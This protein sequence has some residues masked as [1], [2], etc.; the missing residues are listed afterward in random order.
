LS[1]FLVFTNVLYLRTND[2][3]LKVC[4][5]HVAWECTLINIMT[6]YPDSGTLRHEGHVDSSTILP[7]TMTS[8]SPVSS[9]SWD[10]SSESSVESG[11]VPDV[12][13]AEP[14]SEQIGFGGMYYEHLQQSHYHPRWEFKFPDPV[15]GHSAPSR[16]LEHSADVAVI[17]SPQ[18]VGSRG[19]FT[20]R[21]LSGPGGD[22]ISYT[23]EANTKITNRLRRRCFN[24]KATETSTWRRSVLSPGKLVGFQGYLTERVHLIQSQLCNKC[25][26]F[27]RTHAIPRPQKFPRRR[28]HG[29]KVIRP[30]SSH[31]DMRALSGSGHVNRYSKDI[32]S[33]SLPITSH[34]HALDPISGEIIP[35][36]TPWNSPEPPARV[37]RC[38]ATTEEPAVYHPSGQ[39]PPTALPGAI[40]I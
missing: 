26:L 23:D 5:F 33:P 35:Q 32:E 16:T 4:P 27:E 38:Y 14:I 7:I 21:S 28:T 40:W 29:T 1:R 39:F 22:N 8:H 31:P 18:L 15:H 36:H 20:T 37:S 9:P 25:G 2:P 6:R 34:L 13:T 12:P 19:E 11:L 10:I 3:R 30:P 24:C 17:S